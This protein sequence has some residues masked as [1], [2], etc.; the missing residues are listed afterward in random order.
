MIC[1][2]NNIIKKA[3][4]E[5]KVLISQFYMSFTSIFFLIQ[6]NGGLVDKELMSKFNA[7]L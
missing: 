4:A 1:I 6:V 5:M 7:L 2:L 3:A